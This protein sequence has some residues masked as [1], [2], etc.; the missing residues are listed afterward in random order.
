[1]LDPGGARETSRAR[2]PPA[3]EPVPDARAT[4]ST[5]RSTATRAVQRALAAAG[6]AAAASLVASCNLIINVSEYKV[7][8]PCPT[9]DCAT[10]GFGFA[11][12]T[13]ASCV[14]KSCCDEAN[15]C[16]DD[17]TCA[18]LYDCVTACDAADAKCRNA[19]VA[20]HPVGANAAARALDVCL[21]QSDGCGASCSNCGGLADWYADE[22]AACVQSKCCGHATKCADDDA[23]AERQ[24]CYRTC[25]Y[26]TCPF[27]CDAQVAASTGQ[28]LTSDVI[29][30]FDTCT[31][32]GCSAQCAH[33]THWGC[34]G[35]FA[36]PEPTS[37]AMVNVTFDAIQFGTTSAAFPGATIRACASTDHPCAQP[38]AGTEDQVTD[39]KGVA[40]I[41][42]P[43]GFK[44]YFH[45]TAPNT[46]ETLDYVA[47]P[48]TVD[49]HHSIYLGSYDLYKSMVMQAGGGVNDA[50]GAVF[51][52]TYDCLLSAAPGVSLA[53]D[54][55]SEDMN[56]TSHFYFAGSTPVSATDATDGNGIGGWS[57]VVP[58]KLA[59]VTATQYDTQ[60]K[61]GVYP[62]YVQ[63]G[64]ITF[65]SLPP[66]P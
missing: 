10:C 41:G 13:C 52:F 18:P 55:E 47:W 16:H 23:C 56:W 43:S 64:A 17:A 20:A 38:L 11:S 14:E 63:P 37:D 45:V 26:P 2:V 27:D 61:I 62:V 40:T 8:G 53:L 39:D 4:Q 48:I 7:G 19:C 22:C 35:Q 57:N 49:Q 3:R 6:I 51:V 32:Q 31:S 5:R 66:T 36:W 59:T 12:S 30:N 33:G 34:V 25:T 9:G 28:P 58:N 1:M 65:L 46:M 54:H 42:V 15:A 60:T 50:Y 21:S 24:R 29:A 44:G